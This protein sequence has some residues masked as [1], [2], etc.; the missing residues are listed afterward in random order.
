[1][2]A[3]MFLLLRFMG[4][5]IFP[6]KMCCHSLS[7]FWFMVVEYFLV[8]AE[9]MERTISIWWRSVSK[10]GCIWRWRYVLR[11]VVD[12]VGNYIEERNGLLGY[13]NVQKGRHY[14]KKMM[15]YFSTVW[16][17]GKLSIKTFNA[18]LQRIENYWYDRGTWFRNFFHS[19]IHFYT[20]VSLP[21]LLV[22]PLFSIATPFLMI[23]LL[24]LID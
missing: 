2:V 20:Q 5:S 18:W 4:C 8:G 23:L 15:D 9:E 14:M 12:W 19:F 3:L 24:N 11:G 1:M 13:V 16:K 22:L 17:S 7:F 21:L 10:S 6:I